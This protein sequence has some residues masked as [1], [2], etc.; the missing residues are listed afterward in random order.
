[1]RE[2]SV[3]QADRTWHG[4]CHG[5]HVRSS[6]ERAEQVPDLS[7][8]ADVSETLQTLLTDA[9]STL[10]PGPPVAEVHDL[11]GTISTAPARMTIFLFQAIED[12]TVR[13]QRRFRETVPPNIAQRRSQVPLILRYLLT[14]WSGDRATDHRLLGC[15]LQTLHDDAILSGPQLQGGLAGTSE[16]IKLKLA[17]L[18]LEEQTR[19]WHAVQKPYRLSLTYEVRVIR[20]DSGDV[21]VRPPVL[22]RPLD[23]AAGDGA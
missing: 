14:P 22:S 2:P 8:I 23:V 12:P 18:T 16:A 3:S 21:R 6:F 15:A 1:M 20:I 5:A 7:V 17:S 9:F 19:V 10:T 11:Q 13:N 4:F